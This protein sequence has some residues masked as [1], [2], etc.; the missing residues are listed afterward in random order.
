MCTVT[1]FL[2]DEK[3]V[4]TSNR[5]ERIARPTLLPL[6]YQ[7]KGKNVLFPRD[8]EA[9]GTWIASGDNGRLACLLNGADKKHVS[10][11]NYARSRGQILLNS[12][13]FESIGQFSNQEN[14]EN[15][16]PF[17]LIL[18]DCLKKE[19]IQLRW[20][21][22][23]KKIEVLP[24]KGAY[25]WCSYTLYPIEVIEQ[26]SENF[27]ELVANKKPLTPESILSFHEA[28]YHGV[29]QEIG[30]SNLVLGLKTVSLTQIQASSDQISMAYHDLIYDMNCLNKMEI[31]K[32]NGF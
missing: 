1:Y 10:R 6:V 23:V 14:F 19:L 7:V 28:N 17:T 5:D 8:Q 25:I 9:G 27:S 32:S 15:I 31:K 21:G 29:N 26:R 24:F 30:D 2:N 13:S 3:I 22:E 18:V 11:G 12:F 16:E 4:L 20:N